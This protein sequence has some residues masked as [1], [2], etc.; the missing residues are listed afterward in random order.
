MSSFQPFEDD[1]Q[2]REQSWW[3]E[4][5]RQ[6]SNLGVTESDSPH[7]ARKVVLT[8]QIGS[9]IFIIGLMLMLGFLA[10]D[11][12]TVTVNWFIVLII[13]VWTVPFFNFL[14]NRSLARHMLSTVLTVFLVLFTAHTRSEYP[15]TVHEASYYVPRFFL[16]AL[17]FIPLILFGSDERKHLIPSFLLNVLILLGFNQIMDWSGAGMGVVEEQVKDPFFISVSSVAALV[18]ISTGYFFLNRLNT[19]YEVQIEELLDTTS[20][21]N[22]RM[23]DAVNYAKNIQRVVL[24]R[25]S[26]LAELHEQLFVMYRPLHTV[27]GD[28]FMVEEDEDNL[29]LSAIDCT[30]HGVP[31]AFVSILASTALQRAVSNEGLADPARILTVANRYFHQDLSKSGNPDIRDGMDMVMCSLNKQTHELHIAG[32]NLPVFVVS[33]GELTT[34]RTDKGGISIGHPD[35]QFTKQTISLTQSDELF[36]SSDGYWDQFGG[37]KDKR[38]GKRRFRELLL[39]AVQLPLPKQHEHLHDYF[40]KWKDDTFQVDDVC[41]I[42]YRCASG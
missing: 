34:Y 23:Q 42:G 24:P 33:N 30:G 9:I 10:T 19:Q 32:A 18:V 17:S 39:E 8:N 7:F 1:R 2:S 21:Q 38:I 26:K 41:L 4:A 13:G 3:L 20:Q 22:R 40:M 29:L 35:R 27:S 11:V 37:P 16:M 6:L 15:D 28:F 14:G 25:D 36:L 5:W 12:P 31:G